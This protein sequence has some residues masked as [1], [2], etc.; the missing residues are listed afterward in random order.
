MHCFR[1]S[2]D[3]CKG[4]NVA[5]FSLNFPCITLSS[6]SDPEQC[7]EICVMGRNGSTIPD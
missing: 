6:T 7:D 2:L 4:K 3:I 1:F 5:K